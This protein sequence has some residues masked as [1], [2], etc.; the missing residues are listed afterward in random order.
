MNNNISNI[1]TMY[2]PM[3]LAIFVALSLASNTHAEKPSKSRWAN[4]G[5]DRV[6][7]RP[8]E[9]MSFLRPLRKLNLS[10]DQR[11]EINTVIAAHRENTQEQR[12]RVRELKIKLT[13]L[14]PSFNDTTA[15]GLSLQ[16]GELMGELEYTKIAVRAEIYQTLTPDQRDKLVATTVFG[17]GL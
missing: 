7:H 12:E 11:E 16:L 9:M 5:D 14:I 8:K 6:S 15:Q 2:L 3:I 4:N 13:E 17:K 10:E 1:K